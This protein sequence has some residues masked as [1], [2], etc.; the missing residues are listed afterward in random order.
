MTRVQEALL[1][2]T[3]LLVVALLAV[4]EIVP[5]A[6]AQYAP[7]AALPFLLRGGRACAITAAR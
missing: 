5:E 7:L 2:G 1:L 4:F 6:V 3:V